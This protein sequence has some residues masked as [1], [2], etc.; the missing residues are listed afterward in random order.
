[1]RKTSQAHL[2]DVNVLLAL[3]DQTSPSHETA[4]D[5]LK[6][7]KS[8][9]WGT[10]PTTENGFIRIVCNPKYPSGPVSPKQAIQILAGLKAID[11]HRFVPDDYSLLESAGLVE[12]LTG[13]NQITDL[14][15]VELARRNDMTFAT[16]D[17]RMK[18][19]PA[20]CQRYIEYL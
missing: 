9:G 6:E 8:I 20:S 12:K 13:H 18:Y 14:Y 7:R 16:F 17:S 15:I 4:H 3:V 10:C 2:V 1:M 11:G 19:L 5:W